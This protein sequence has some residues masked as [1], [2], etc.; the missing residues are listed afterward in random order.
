[1][2]DNSWTVEDSEYLDH[3][4]EIANYHHAEC[5]SP[6][7]A[8]EDR[9]DEQEALNTAMLAIESFKDCRTG[10]IESLEKAVSEDEDQQ[11]NS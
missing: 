10:F 6:L 4:I 8:P 3:L 2:S 5:I 9:A 11:Q 1:M 7:M